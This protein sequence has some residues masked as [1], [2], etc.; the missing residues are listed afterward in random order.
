MLTPEIPSLRCSA[1]TP[2]QLL[3]LSVKLQP[4]ICPFPVLGLWDK[5]HNS[6]PVSR[7]LSEEQR[8]HSVVDLAVGRGGVDVGVPGQ[9]AQAQMP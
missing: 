5:T 4:G 1:L 2:R 3:T 6:M 8:T 7:V 9:I